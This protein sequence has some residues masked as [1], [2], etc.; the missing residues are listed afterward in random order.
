MYVPF[1]PENFDKEFIKK[2][3]G[4]STMNQGITNNLDGFIRYFTAANIR[5]KVNFKI[6]YIC[7]ISINNHFI[8]FLNIIY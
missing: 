1:S 6:N 3:K 2:R 4:K 5:Q 8:C 7:S